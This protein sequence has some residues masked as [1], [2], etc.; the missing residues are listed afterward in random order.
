VRVIPHPGA[1]GWYGD[2][3]TLFERFDVTLFQDDLILPE[4]FATNLDCLGISFGLGDSF[5]NKGGG[6]RRE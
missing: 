2:C 5:V 4:C 6:W 3:L 1:V